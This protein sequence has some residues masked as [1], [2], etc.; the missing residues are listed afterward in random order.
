MRKKAALQLPIHEVQVGDHGDVELRR[1]SALDEVLDE[2]HV[3]RLL[4]RHLGAF[5]ERLGQRRSRLGRHLDHLTPVLLAM[6]C[7]LLL[8]LFAL[9]VLA[10]HLFLQPQSEVH[11]RHQGRARRRHRGALE[12]TAR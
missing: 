6:R 11:L 12:R 8:L 1:Y 7:L 3:L 10:P 9:F 5:L 2:V 4:V